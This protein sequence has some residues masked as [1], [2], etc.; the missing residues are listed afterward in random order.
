MIA[1]EEIE[2]DYIDAKQASIQLGLSLSRISRL[3][4]S[5]RFEGAFKAGGSWLIPRK[6]VEEHEPLP[7]GPKKNYYILTQA[8]NKAENLKEDDN[9]DQQ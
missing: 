6:A 2:R 3:C 1:Q 7:P 4:S 9:N 8:I 5:G